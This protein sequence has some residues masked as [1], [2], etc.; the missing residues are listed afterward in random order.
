MNDNY[1]FFEI[2][3]SVLH[4]IPRFLLNNHDYCPRDIRDISSYLWFIN[5]LKGY[6]TSSIYYNK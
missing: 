2:L 4:D 3:S 6:P 1:T 5:L